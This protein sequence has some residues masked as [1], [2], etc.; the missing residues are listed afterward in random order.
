M[1]P[2][3]QHAHDTLL[4]LC[5]TGYCEIDKSTAEIIDAA[6]NKDINLNSKDRSYGTYLI[7][8]AKHGQVDVIKD[9]I[10]SGATLNEYDFQGF[11]ALSHSFASGSIKSIQYLLNQG[12]TH[13]EKHHNLHMALYAAIC[14]QNIPTITGLS[15]FSQIDLNF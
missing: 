9:L 1:F 13:G 12:A 3:K 15:I 8:A 7:C 5:K 10:L 11:T 6:K 4:T 14:Y 2:S